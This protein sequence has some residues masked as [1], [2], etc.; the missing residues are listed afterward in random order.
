M[1]NLEIKLE[2]LKEDYPEFYSFFKEALHNSQSK[3]KNNKED[4]YRC[5]YYVNSFIKPS[6]R[7]DDYYKNLYN[8]KWEERSKEEYSKFKV[9]ITM[10]SGKFAI[11][12]QTNVIAE[13]LNPIIDEIIGR[14]MY[15][16]QKYFEFKNIEVLESIPNLEELK[17]KIEEELEN[18]KEFIKMI[19][20]KLETN[21]KEQNDISPQDMLKKLINEEKYEDAEELINKFPELKRK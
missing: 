5:Y 6:Q 9:T 18:Q 13:S 20:L 21:F 4:K 14:K 15:L 1:V 19:G 7:T 8:M 3:F 10:V 12:D 17:N 11:S 16:E 2:K